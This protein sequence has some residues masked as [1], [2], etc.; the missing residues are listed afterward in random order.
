LRERRVSNKYQLGLPMERVRGCGHCQCVR[1][2]NRMKCYGLLI[3]AVLYGSAPAS[4]RS[5]NVF[6]HMYVCRSPLQCVW[7]MLISVLYVCKGNVPWIPQLLPGFVPCRTSHVTH[8]SS[9]SR[10]LSGLFRSPARE[11][12]R[13]IRSLPSLRLLRFARRGWSITTFQTGRFTHIRS[14]FVPSQHSALPVPGP[15]R[16]RSIPVLQISTPSAIVLHWHGCTFA[17]VRFCLVAFSRATRSRNI[18]MGLP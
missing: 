9:P 18:T 16:R 3:T 7:H 12:I 1:C 15:R 5:D 13:P 8:N 17:L 2:G 11:F 6:V 14:A 4:T 10:V